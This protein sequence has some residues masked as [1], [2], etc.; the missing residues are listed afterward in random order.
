MSRADPGDGKISLCQSSCLVKDN[1]ADIR[2]CLHEIG[3]LNQ[4][5]LAAGSSDPSEKGQGDA[6]HNGAGAADDEKCQRAV[7][8]FGP[9]CPSA[10]PV[11]EN[12][13]HD[14]PQHCQR[15]SAVTDGRCIPPGKSGDELLGFCLP[16]T[17]ILHQIQDP[18][19][20]RLLK[21]PGRLYSQDSGLVDRSAQDLISLRNVTGQRFPCERGGIQRRRT[22]YDH[23]VDRHP[24]PGLDEQD[25][26]CLHIIRI[27]L[28]HPVLR[29][30]I[31]IVRTDI[32]QFTDIAAA[33]SDSDALE[34]LTDLVKEHDSHSL[35]IFTEHHGSDRRNCHQE[36]FVK[37]LP[38]PDPL[39]CLSQDIEAHG[40]VGHQ[41]KQK[42]DCR[43]L[44]QRQ[45]GQQDHHYYGGQDPIE[46]LFLFFC[47]C[48]HH[49]HRVV[50]TAFLFTA[51]SPPYAFLL[52][53][54]CGYPGCGR[55]G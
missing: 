44:F 37:Y 27:H 29:H 21:L 54:G 39:E 13:A 43:V 28:L 10:A 40:K 5:S 53:P 55:S 46:Q 42:A 2:Q 26:A 48:F 24:F 6:D 51:K 36:I 35:G 8:P 41:E 7:D 1:C 19:C 20:G 47:Q 30:Q 16:G 25:T 12:H 17:S 15:E 3:T 34:E 23:S 9:Q 49:I 4:D 38:V 52:L 11:Q 22:L 50:Q 14:G 31:G 18:G 45:N 32:H 33:L